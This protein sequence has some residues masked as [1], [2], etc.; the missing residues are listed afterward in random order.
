M[1]NL[2]LYE[3]RKS[4][5][6]LVVMLVAATL[7][8]CTGDQQDAGGYEKGSV[9]FALPATGRR[10]IYQTRAAA[11]QGEDDVTSL[12]IYQFSAAGVLEKIH[13]TG[14]TIDGALPV[15]ITS[16][17]AAGRVATIN[18]GEETGRKTFYLV[19]NVNGTG[20]VQ[21]NDLASVAPGS[22]TTDEF[23]ENLVTDELAGTNGALSLTT[24][25]PMSNTLQGAV[26]GIVVADV[27]A[28]GSLQVTMKRRVAR[29][30]VVNHAAYTGFTVKKI[31]VRD[32][33]LSGEILDA[34]L[35]RVP[36]M[37]D[38]ETGDLTA[39][40]N[41]TGDIDPATDYI[42]PGDA[43]S[44]LSAA[45]LA[46][47]LNPALFYLY[48]TTVSTSDGGTRVFIVGEHGGVEHVYPLTLAA[49]ALIEAN[50]VYQIK[51][52][53]AV[54]AGKVEFDLLPVEEWTDDATWLEAGMS[55]AP[56][57]FSNFTSTAGADLGTTDLDFSEASNGTEVRIETYSTTATGTSV[58]AVLPVKNAGGVTVE[59]A[60]VNA[61]VT[62]SSGTPVLTRSSGQVSFKQVHVITLTQ[63]PVPFKAALT[64][65]DLTN[66]A[67]TATYTL[68]SVGRYDGRATLKPVLVGGIYWAPVNAGA[69]QLA[70]SY[71]ST[72]DLTVPRVGYLYQWGRDARF[73]NT[74]PLTPLSGPVSA[75]VAALDENK[76]RFITTNAHPNDWLT[77]K[78]DNLWSGAN[79]QGPCPAGWRLPTKEEFDII[80]AKNAGLTSR[81]I[82]VPGDDSK[83][84]LYFPAS[85]YRS[86]ETSEVKNLGSWGH[87]WSS[88][89]N[90]L[91]IYE[92]MF[93][94]N[95]A[96]ITPNIRANGYPVRCVQQ[97]PPVDEEEE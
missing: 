6:F 42:I 80:V 65:Q 83:S 77:S 71:L 90:N 53:R 63:P 2:N 91:N 41:G 10:V 48:P 54:A 32:G 88:T 46:R 62:V 70:T 72:D 34:D 87:Y 55:A 89:P 30:D 31:V 35:S 59:Q 9:S 39:T 5:L 52:K 58:T 28:P 84:Y 15:T 85:G 29:F 16:D 12:A 56:T 74:S 67:L 21:S 1:L 69:S 49:D 96:S 13:A 94:T 50:H 81:V 25:L 95:P 75:E 3:M 8:G 40:A 60:V 68:S 97:S 73:D 20:Q 22:T 33:N 23:E 38:G 24:P 66:P 36:G 79:A 78:N 17:N 64:V 93:S 45:G 92:F 44:G 43:A 11:G 27:R 76:T 61:A 19:A 18:I 51:V 37:G 4:S 7:A 26:K 14:V 82:S 57:G 47:S 86:F